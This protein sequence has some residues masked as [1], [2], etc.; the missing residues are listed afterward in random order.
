MKNTIRRESTSSRE[1][2]S[3]NESMIIKRIKSSG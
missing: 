2:M 1:S 3:S